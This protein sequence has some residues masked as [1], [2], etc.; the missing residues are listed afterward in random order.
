MVVTLSPM[1]DE[2]FTKM[3]SEGFASQFRNLASY[4]KAET[5]NSDAATGFELRNQRC[6]N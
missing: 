6:G 1:H 5:S 4:S 2:E 3:A